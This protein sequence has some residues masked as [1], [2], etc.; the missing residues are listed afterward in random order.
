MIDEIRAGASGSEF[1]FLLDYSGLNVERITELRNKLHSVGAQLRVVKNRLFKRVADELDW[2]EIVQ[3]LHG[4]TAAVSGDDDVA[5]A[6]ILREL[7]S[8]DFRPV[9]KGGV[10]RGVFLTSKEIEELATLP[11]REVLLGICVGTI[12]A[13]MSQL[14]GVMSSKL[15]SLVRILKAVEEKKNLG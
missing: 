13:P 12:A 9:M 4:P 8:V 1:V 11:T 3:I 10:I 6:K 5:A 14:V 15:S 2:N 7:A